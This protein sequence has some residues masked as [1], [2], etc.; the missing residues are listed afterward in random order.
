[1]LSI[2]LNI[3]D[4]TFFVYKDGEFAGLLEPLF[5]KQKDGISRWCKTDKIVFVPE[6][7]KEHVLSSYER[8]YPQIHR[9]RK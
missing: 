1:M 7:L 5:E 8:V 9:V 2:I 6:H 4:G 3:T